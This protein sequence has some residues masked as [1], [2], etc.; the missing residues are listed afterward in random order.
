[1]ASNSWSSM[2]DS[3]KFQ[4]IGGNRMIG[5]SG[6]LPRHLDSP[7]VRGVET[8]PPRWG[9]ETLVQFS[10]WIVPHLNLSGMPSLALLLPFLTSD[11]D[12]GKW[13]DCWVSMEFLPT[14]IPRKESG[15]T[16][17][18]V[19]V[20]KKEV[21]GFI[22][23]QQ[24]AQSVSITTDIYCFCHVGRGTV[25]A[26]ISQWGGGLAVFFGRSPRGHLGSWGLSLGDFCN[27]SIKLTHF[28]ALFGQNS[29]LKQ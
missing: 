18:R 11:P 19:A 24:K 4:T 13:P 12:L 8:A 23:S 1:M 2:R 10:F 7:L 25:V 22:R 9:G 16:T 14:S 28:Y 17:T 3:C 27:F 6:K 15:S 5:P 20:L 26:R 21:G 29:Y